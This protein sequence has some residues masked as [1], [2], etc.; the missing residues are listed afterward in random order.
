MLRECPMKTPDKKPVLPK[1][2]TI[3]AVDDTPE[4]LRLLTELLGSRGYDVRP[5]TNGKLALDY[6]QT[7]LP[8][9]I[10]LDIK[11]PDMSG[12]EV[13]ERLQA[14]ERTRD[15]PVIFISA[16]DEIGD[17][18]KGF[19]VGGVDYIT[20]PF[21]MKEVV[22]RVETHLKLRHLWHQ[23]HIANEH[24]EHQL[25]ESERLNVELQQRNAE[26][27]EA[28]RTIKTLSGLVPICAWCHK[29][30][31][32]EEGE[33]M[34]LESYIENHSEA[35]FTHG[36]CPACLEKMKEESHSS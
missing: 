11:M 16:L 35:K 26:L 2:A 20:K 27:Q 1:K 3:L 22:A 14:D 10:L 15:I 21:Q 8:D 30:I 24:L 4:N 7:T 31:K 23:L 33:W 32:N 36:I 28:L 13:C 18:V 25:E 34:N 9:L 5:A 6:V 29:T 19:A 12:F 17:K